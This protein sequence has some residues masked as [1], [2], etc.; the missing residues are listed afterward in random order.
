VKDKIL[1]QI[2]DENEKQGALILTQALSAPPFARNTGF[3]SMAALKPDDGYCLV[4]CAPHVGITQD[5]V[6]SK[7]EREGIALVDN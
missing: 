3:R 4:I 6:I 5:R 7:V 2:E 1:E